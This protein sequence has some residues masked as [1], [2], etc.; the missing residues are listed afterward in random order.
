MEQ[1][2]GN[3]DLLDSY[4]ELQGDHIHKVDA[5]LNTFEEVAHRATGKSRESVKTE[6][7]FG[8]ERKKGMAFKRVLGLLYEAAEN[9][10][11]KHKDSINTEDKNNNNF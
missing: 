6:I 7:D 9:W 1:K 3:E 11:E 5:H 2:R 4:V 8:Q 10:Q